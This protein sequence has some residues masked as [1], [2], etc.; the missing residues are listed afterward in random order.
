MTRDLEERRWSTAAKLVALFATVGV[1]S[2]GLCGVSVLN[3]L[4][5]DQWWGS[6]ENVT[7]KLFL[8]CVAGL[9]VSVI[10]MVGSK[11]R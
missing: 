6:V 9:V 1:L 5:G 8:F 4:G 7:S 10:Y 11:R 3:A 2:F